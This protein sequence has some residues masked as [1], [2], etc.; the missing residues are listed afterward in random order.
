MKFITTLS[1][2]FIFC[3]IT[4]GQIEYKKGY[5]VTNDNVKVEC[6]IQYKET[7]KNP[8][9]IKIKNTQKSK[10][11]IKTV[12]DIK[13]FTIYN[14]HKYIRAT[15][16]IDRSS[17]VAENLSFEPNPVW[18]KETL[19]LQVILV[20]QA[21][22]YY[23]G[24]S[25]ISRYF[26]SISNDTIHQL[27]YRIYR[28]HKERIKPQME[29]NQEKNQENREQRIPF[30]YNLYGKRKLIDVYID[31]S[32]KLQ[33][34]KE[35][36]CGNL[37]IPEIDKLAYSGR[38]LTPYFSKYNECVNSSNILEYHAE[39]SDSVV[40][41]NKR[42]L[43]GCN[44]SY[45]GID[46]FIG[47]SL[48]LDY[49]IH[50]Q[51]GLDIEVLFPTTS[52]KLALVAQPIYCYYKKNLNLNWIKADIHFNSVLLPFG[53]RYYFYLPNNNRIH[54]TGLILTGINLDMNS[55]I[56]VR[57][58]ESIVIEFNPGF[59]LNAGF[60]HKRMSISYNY[61]TCNSRSTTDYLYYRGSSIV[62]GYL[63][64]K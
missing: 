3:T 36:N 1:F 13:E 50:P 44:R 28:T 42:I 60:D 34:Y 12:T 58:S 22:L 11:E 54:I 30:Y 38:Q 62:F 33:L 43:L 56:K 40:K 26:Y 23:Y 17:D 9:K 20:G 4:F 45:F 14:V 16:N 19:F 51:I 24:D 8:T 47:N 32:Y 7:A 59:A 29:L 21:S 5:Y 10:P 6:L 49:Q 2:L 37:S 25:E 53:L 35:V 52:N 63:L 41:T 39:L 15:V 61:Y 64:N 27:V 55:T 48:K 18:Q 57:G 46:N 31:Q